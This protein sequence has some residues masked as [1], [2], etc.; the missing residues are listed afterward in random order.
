M[1]D[2]FQAVLFDF[3]G[4]LCTTPMRLMAE[5]AADAGLTMEQ[6]M[7]MALGPTHEDGDYPFHR[8]ER[9][10][11]SMAECR[12][13]LDERARDQGMSGFPPLPTWEEVAAQLVPV[14]EMLAAA[15]A[16]RRA[17]LRTAV[18]SNNFREWSGW[19][20]LVDAENRFDTVIDSSA[21]GLR[22]PDPAIYELALERVGGISPDDAVFL[23]DFE[24]NLGSAAELGLH[25]LHVT[26]PVAGAADLV[27]LLEL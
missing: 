24:W 8:L 23:D 3:A 14:P 19:Q 27:A 15:D 13:L 18:V 21:V 26:D 20:R 12:E 11:I 16:V 25:T 9:G 7:P 5:K 22:K 6:F 17:G 2:R 4:V 10:E 1:T